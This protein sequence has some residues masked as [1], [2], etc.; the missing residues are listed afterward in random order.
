MELVKLKKKVNWQIANKKNPS[1]DYD[2]YDEDEA[3]DKLEKKYVG[4]IVLSKRGKR[5]YIAY[6]IGYWYDEIFCFS[7][8][9]VDKE[10]EDPI[11]NFRCNDIRLAS[12][13]EAE[14]ILKKFIEESFSSEKVESNFSKRELNSLIRS[15][16]K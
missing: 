6:E 10:I 1:L 13:K 2:Y 7:L 4:R 14:E 3:R 8:T 9:K 16:S 15:L 12:K 5:P 11:V